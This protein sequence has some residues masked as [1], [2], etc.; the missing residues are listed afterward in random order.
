MQGKP[1]PADLL[2]TSAFADV[3]LQQQRRERAP[4]EPQL[5][6]PAEG[7]VVIRFTVR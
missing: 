5:A 3:L 1:H 6:L 4:S 7:A 2:A